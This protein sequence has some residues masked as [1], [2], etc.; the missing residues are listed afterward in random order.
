M[1]ISTQILKQLKQN[2][3]RVLH[4]TD[5]LLDKIRLRF[6]ITGSLFPLDYVLKT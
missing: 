3:L 4:Y 6:R 2:N 1:Y 5:I